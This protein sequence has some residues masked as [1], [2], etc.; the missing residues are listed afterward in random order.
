MLHKALRKGLNRF[1]KAISQCK[2]IYVERY[3]EEILTSERANL[4]IRIRFQKGHFLE[5]NEA[6]V[7]EKNHLVSLDY[8]YHCQDEK[9]RLLFRYD[10]TPHFPQLSSFPSHKH[11]PHD[12]VSSQKPEIDQLLKEAEQAGISVHSF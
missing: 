7:V 3:T 2:D 1:E 5:I 8:R 12:V 4:R 11:I 10:N 9:N 6:F